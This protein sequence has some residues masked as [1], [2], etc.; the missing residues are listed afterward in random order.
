V[1]AGVLKQISS[2][3]GQ[4]ESRDPHPDDLPDVLRGHVLFL[5]VLVPKLP[6]VP[7]PFR[8]QLLPLPGLQRCECDA[9]GATYTGER[10]RPRQG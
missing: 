1:L 7:I 9:T 10:R 2:D 5:A 4:G 8:V 3:R 6:L